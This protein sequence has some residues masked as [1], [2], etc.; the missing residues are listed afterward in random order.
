MRV[1]EHF[2]ALA[3]V[4]LEYSEVDI[5]NTRSRKYD[6]VLV[7]AC[8]INILTRYYGGNTVNVGKAIGND[9][10]TIIHHLRKHSQRFKYEPEY[11]MLYNYLSKYAVASNDSPINVDNLVQIMKRTLAA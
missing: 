1:E 11:N 8:V 5:R 6:I 2:N 9:H 4:A 10:S 3:S 7:K